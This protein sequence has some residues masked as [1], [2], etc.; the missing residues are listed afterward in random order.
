MP[1]QV[2]YW[3]CLSRRCSPDTTDRTRSGTST[4]SAATLQSVSHLPGN[5]RHMWKILVWNDL[6]PAERSTALRRP[7]QATQTQT[8]QAVQRI[9]DAVR[10]EGDAALL[11]LTREF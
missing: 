2:Q 11:R 3:Y 6:S 1:A 8:L 9:I 7:A 10:S 5:A 4:R